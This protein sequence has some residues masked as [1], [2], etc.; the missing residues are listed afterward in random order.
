MLKTPH[1]VIRAKALRK[2]CDQIVTTPKT[3][4]S[5]SALY[6]AFSEILLVSH[7]YSDVKLEALAKLPEFV[8]L[9]KISWLDAQIMLEGALKN[10][11]SDVQ[12]QELALAHGKLQLMHA[13]QLSKQGELQNYY[14]TR[15]ARLDHPFIEVISVYPSA[16]D[17]VLSVMK[18]LIV[19]DYR[20]SSCRSLLISGFTPFWKWCVIGSANEAYAPELYITLQQILYELKQQNDYSTIEAL[21]SVAVY[22]I[23]ECIPLYHQARRL[24]KFLAFATSC[25]HFYKDALPHYEAVKRSLTAMQWSLI[26]YLAETKKNF[27]EL[28]STCEVEKE[29][30]YDLIV[31]FTVLCWLLDKEA[32]CET[33]EAVLYAIEKA[34]GRLAL[35]SE[36]KNF[37]CLISQL[38]VAP[39]I[40]I[41]SAKQQPAIKK[42][43]TKILSLV[44]QYRSNLKFSTD[45]RR[46]VLAGAQN[47]FWREFKSNDPAMHAANRYY[48]HGPLM[49]I[50]Q[51]LSSLLQTFPRINL[52]VEKD[53]ASLFQY[54]GVT[55]PLF[56]QLAIKQLVP[57]LDSLP[58]VL[59]ILHSSSIEPI[60]VY[61][62]LNEFL[63]SI[64]SDAAGT[65]AVLGVTKALKEQKRRKILWDQSLLMLERVW[66]VNP[67]VWREL[68]AGLLVWIRASDS[69][70]KSDDVRESI[71]MGILRD[72]CSLRPEQIGNEVVAMLVTICSRREI[73]DPETP[74]RICIDLIK[75][76]TLTVEQAW[77]ALVRD[78]FAKYHVSAAFMQF[79]ALVGQFATD[80]ES[81]MMLKS[82]IINYIM[83]VISDSF[84]DGEDIQR[85][86]MLALA[87]FPLED[88]HIIFQLKSHKEFFLTCVKGSEIKDIYIPILVKMCNDEIEA[89]N[90]SEYNGFR[91]REDASKTSIHIQK[92]I[93]DASKQI[94]Q[95]WDGVNI[96]PTARAGASFGILINP[97]EKCKNSFTDIERSLK[98]IIEDIPG[99]IFTRLFGSWPFTVFWR[100]VL[101]ETDHQELKNPLEKFTKDMLKKFSQEHIPRIR[102]NIALALCSNIY[103]VFQY[104]H[105]F[106][107][108]FD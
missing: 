25:L 39:L 56:P 103:W 100:N 67:R 81:Y 86:T 4:K 53:I 60:T 18:L 16:W 70:D 37:N 3:A 14:S 7:E 13:M 97:P 35:G 90:R 68:K 79:C 23:G 64:C 85:E 59:Y 102:G 10:I 62:I 8:T 87:S 71:V 30:A 42:H 1:A 24:D 31:Y 75:A 34:V 47:F 93:Q 32:S 36:M 105:R 38:A 9:D 54:V 80:S 66:R 33:H 72:C 29:H 78:I 55:Y 69:T 41:L 20:D 91:Y 83:T 99:D 57:H 77:D 58:L 98:M 84:R 15:Q 96:T 92:I 19:E 40:K 17:S 106:G 63:P 43:A 51:A 12:A 21:V 26:C 44:E 89:M 49:K 46:K 94:F 28:I 11:T 73:R 52:F 104:Y 27:N 50:S 6:S 45:E 88:I 107:F 95:Q 22:Q 82:E 74:V 48:I 2:L 108:C 61:Q 5:F 101:L 65:S 76:K